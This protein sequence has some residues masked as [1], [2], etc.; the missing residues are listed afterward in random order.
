MSIINEVT[1]RRSRDEAIEALRAKVEALKEERD[2]YKQAADMLGLVVTQWNSDKKTVDVGQFNEPPWPWDAMSGEELEPNTA[3][4]VIN[5]FGRGPNI[6]NRRQ[7]W[8]DA[9]FIAAARTDIDTL[10]DEVERLRADANKWYT[11]AQ[12][13]LTAFQFSREQSATLGNEI[14]QAQDECRA[15]EN[16]NQELRAEVERLR[17]ALAELDPWRK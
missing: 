14:I 2:G 17:A 16:E 1:E 5:Y 4:E 12:Q 11:H 8:R 6:R 9:E 7:A 10:L 15:K 13:T 3:F